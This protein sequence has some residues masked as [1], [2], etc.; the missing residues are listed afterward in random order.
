MKLSKEIIIAGIAVIV[1]MACATVWLM[2]T[3][4]R[5]APPL[6]GKTLDGRTLTL[7]QFRGKPVLVTFWATTCPGCIEEMPHLIDLYRDLNPKGLEII[8][9]AMAYDPPEQV[10]TL[11]AQRQIPYPIVLDTQ[12]RIAREF[13]NVQLTPTSVLISPDGRIVEYRL[14]ALDMPKLRQTIGAML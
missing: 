14:G 8:G 1:V 7:Q 11:A 12:A 3:G 5:Q 9:V 13:D 6:V 10:R 4:L 2:P